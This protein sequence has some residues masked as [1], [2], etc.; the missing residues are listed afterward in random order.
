M[1]VFVLD[2]SAL[3]RFVDK[4]AGTD[5]IAEIFAAKEAGKAKVLMSA[6]HWG[7]VV[8]ILYRRYGLNGADKPLAEFRVLAIEVIPATEQRAERTAAI[9]HRYKIPYAD[10]FGVELASDSAHHCL[11]TADFDVKPAAQDIFIEFLP[12]KPIP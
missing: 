3:F 9:R 5:R 6:V 8:H 12:I 1:V 7:E 10:A 2:T 11:V 4:E